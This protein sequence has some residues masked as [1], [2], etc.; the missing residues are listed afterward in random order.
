MTNNQ[1]MDQPNFFDSG[2]PFL[3]H[4]LLTDERTTVEIGFILSQFALSKGARILDVGCGFGRHSIELARRGFAVTSIDPSAAMLA[5][6]KKRAK[7]TAVSLTLQ[8]IPAEQF[9]TVE[10]FAAAICLFTTLGQISAADDNSGL[11][12]AVYRALI[13]GGKIVVEVPQR[14]MAVAQ[15]KTNDKFGN[16]ER[17]TAVTRQYDSHTQIVSESFLVVTP[18][19]SQTYLL[20][21]RLFSFSD[22]T[23][24]LNAAGYE[25]ISA[26]SDYAGTPLTND[27]PNMLLIGQ[28]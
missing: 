23:T 17:Y 16:G 5:A 11:L 1:K 13:P 22:L 8:Q 18:E 7:D 25:V 12:G 28:K 2:S 15:L 27:S 3:D 14:E 26:F 6:A 4:P 19:Q 24:L 10:P 20:R 21:Y 9:T